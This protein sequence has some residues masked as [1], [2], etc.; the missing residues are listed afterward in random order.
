MTKF[1]SLDSCLEGVTCGS[2]RTKR[3]GFCQIALL[4]ESRGVYDISLEIKWT[5]PVCY[6]VLRYRFSKSADEN[7]R[8]EAGQP[9]PALTKDEY[10]QLA[11]ILGPHGLETRR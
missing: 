1:S 3:T 4:Y 5:F 11:E 10:K 6:E 2:A 7:E 8:E 9:R